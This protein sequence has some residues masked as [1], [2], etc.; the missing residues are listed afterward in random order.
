MSGEWCPRRPRG[1]GQRA[2]CFSLTAQPDLVHAKMLNVGGRHT[3]KF[4]KP[5]RLPFGLL[6]PFVACIVS[7]G[8]LSAG[9]GADNGAGALPYF[10]L[11]VRST[12]RPLAFGIL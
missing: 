9:E 7:G 12:V 10:C 11:A 5:V 6:V 1:R 8:M 3:C 4:A 2:A